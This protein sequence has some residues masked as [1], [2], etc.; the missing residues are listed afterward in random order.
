MRKLF[1]LLFLIITLT[2]CEK[3][4]D[5]DL[6]QVPSQIIIRGQITNQPGF[7]YIQITRSNDFY[8]SGKTP[9]VTNAFVTVNDDAG[10]EIQFIHNPS[11]FD[12]LSGYYF[13]G[14]SF[15]G[16]T[17]HTY[18]LHIEVDGEVYEAQDHLSPVLSVDSISYEIDEDEFSDP[19]DPGKY[20]NVKLYAKEPQNSVDYY[21]F[22]FY[23]NDTLVYDNETD[24][25]YTDDKTLAEDIEG[26]EA[27]AFY[28]YG[29]TVNI[30]VFSISREAFV[31]YNDLST[32]LNNDGG[33]FAPP[34]AN[35]RNNLTNGALGFFQ[36]SA[37]H[38]SQ[39]IIGQ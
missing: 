31:F 2:A 1:V 9:R 24:I 11:G 13:P 26:V 36:T 25:Y 35:S 34:P 12:A 23:R 28:G 37:V 32:L 5:L 19:Q 20:Y 27:P 38:I 39:V 3:T 21:L 6:E 29:D 14:V 30:Q 22:K 10:N 7:Q 15:Q 33:M 8:S 16:E 18:Y 17:G 4:V